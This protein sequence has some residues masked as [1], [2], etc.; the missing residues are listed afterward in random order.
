MERGDESQPE[1]A[2]DELLRRTHADFV[3]LNEE[4]RLAKEREAAAQANLAEAERQVDGLVARALPQVHRVV[5]ATLAEA[6]AEAASV[7]GA[8]EARARE[9]SAEARQLFRQVVS[10]VREALD[11]ALGAEPPGLAPPPAP[12]APP[13]P[14]PAIQ[15]RS[16][17]ADDD[18]FAALREDGPGGVALGPEWFDP[19]AATK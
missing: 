12:P 4:I 17:A 6:D 13:E 8:A 16:P 18:W 10:Q 19:P 3:R 7:L 1:L 2:A 5:E 9:V 11:D 15:G 14:A